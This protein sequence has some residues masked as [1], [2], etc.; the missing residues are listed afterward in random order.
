MT[1]FAP[2]FKEMIRIHP[3]SVEMAVGIRI[4]SLK[5]GTT[6]VTSLGLECGLV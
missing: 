3:A 1:L 5:G 6:N 2:P 4:I